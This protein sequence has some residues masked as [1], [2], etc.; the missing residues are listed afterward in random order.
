MEI[1][2][3][4]CKQANRVLLID[5]LLATGGTLL[6]GQKLLQRIGAEIMDAAVIID[7]PELGG[8]EKCRERGLPVY[9]LIQFSGH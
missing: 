1:H 2:I 3:D 9:S 6:A 8:G 7:L 5:D 4:A